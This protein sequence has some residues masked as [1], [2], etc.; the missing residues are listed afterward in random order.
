MFMYIVKF[1]F[2]MIMSNLRYIKFTIW[3]ST[4]MRSINVYYVRE[5]QICVAFIRYLLKTLI[6]CTLSFVF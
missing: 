1:E 3:K 5:T 2:G 4:F 6:G